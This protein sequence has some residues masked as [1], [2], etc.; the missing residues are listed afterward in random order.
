MKFPPEQ[1]N[2]SVWYGPDWLARQREWITVLSSQEIA[3]LET[4]AETWDRAHPDENIEISQV[5]DFSLPTLAPK[6]LQLR[7]ELI[8]GR[9]FA[10]LRGL[11]VAKYSEREAAIIFSGLG[12]H[13]GSSRSQNKL[14]HLLGHVRDLGLASNDPN[15]RVYQTNE[16][17]T[18][19]TDSCD[20]VGLL[21]LVTAKRGGLSLLV[22]SATIFNEMLLR[23]PDLA[24]LLFE[25][26][27]TDRRGE[28]PN[29]MLPYYL[30]PVFNYYEGFLTAIYQ[31][32]Y[33]ES[34]QRFPDAPRLTQKHID[35]LDLFDELANSRE[36][37][38]P[39][40]LEAGDMQFVYNHTLLHDRTS[41][42]DWPE[43]ERKRHLLRLWLSIPG[44][45][46]LPKIFEQKFG[47]VTIGDR[48]GII[49]EK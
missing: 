36:L 47:S 33:I 19:H 7:N 8:N 24:A 21:C 4:A 39:M 49:L 23:R 30:I 22:S 31:R 6:L 37:N 5:R 46:P 44:D 13:L 41:F 16:R 12:S 29:G 17:Q 45:R 25:E 11:P 1:K 34:A 15:V 18:F 42:E 26:I 2:P 27:A 3:E 9:G 38:F 32:Q 28:I 40:T 43:A 10:L 35:A 14:G 48:G 20:V